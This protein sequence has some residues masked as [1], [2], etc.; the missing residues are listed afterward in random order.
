[1]KAVVQ[2]RKN[3]GRRASQTARREVAFTAFLSIAVLTA[4]FCMA[5]KD[6]LN[7]RLSPRFYSNCHWATG[8]SYEYLSPACI[9]LFP[10]FL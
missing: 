1:M 4:S 9:D 6:L 5:L 10:S 3:E 7:R 8:K 2:E